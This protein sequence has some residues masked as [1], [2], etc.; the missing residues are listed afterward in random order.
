MKRKKVEECWEF[1][2][3]PGVLKRCAAL[4]RFSIEKLREQQQNYPY[5]IDSRLISR[6]KK[7]RKI[8]KNIQITA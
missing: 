5:Q 1:E 2:N 7:T 8:A 4:L 3:N 6:E